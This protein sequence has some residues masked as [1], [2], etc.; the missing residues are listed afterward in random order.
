MKPLYFKLSALIYVYPVFY[1]DPCSINAKMS[2]PNILA[3][4]Q[5]GEIGYH[6]FNI[7]A[8]FDKCS[9]TKLRFNIRYKHI[10][11]MGDWGCITTILYVFKSKK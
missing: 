4:F 7:A 10:E 3:K 6:N 2:Y 1:Y 11:Q 8:K 9:T 5:N